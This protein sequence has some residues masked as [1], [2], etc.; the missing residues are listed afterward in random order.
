[1]ATECCKT[2]KIAIADLAKKVL[3]AFV[4]DLNQDTDMIEFVS[5]TEPLEDIPKFTVFDVNQSKRAHET[6][7]RLADAGL[8]DMITALS[9]LKNRYPNSFYVD[10][11]ARIALF[12]CPE[13]KFVPLPPAHQTLQRVMFQKSKYVRT[14]E[15]GVK[16]S[17]RRRFSSLGNPAVQNPEHKLDWWREDPGLSEHHYNWH[18]YYPASEPLKMERQGELFA[19]MHEQ[20]LARYNCERLAVGLPLVV[21]YGPG[22]GWENP[23][24][25]GYNP[26]L[27][28]YSFRALGMNIP[29]STTR[30]SRIIL[31][32]NMIFNKDRL[33]T[34]IARGHLEDRQGQHVPLS[35]TKLGCTV[36][37][38]V[39]SV[40]R[41]LYGNVH[42]NG[43]V[44]L[45]SLNDPDGRYDIEAGPMINT[46]TSAKD[47]VFYR[48]HKFVDSFF[49]YFR[50]SLDP[51]TK[52][53]L[54]I[55]GIELMD[56]AVNSSDHPD[57]NQLF[58]QMKEKYYLVYIEKENPEK[59]LQQV[60]DYTPFQY[61]FTVKNTRK[62][63]AKVVFRVFLAPYRHSDD[64]DERRNDFIELDR[65]VEEIERG[66]EKKVL[67]DSKDSSVLLP[68]GVTIEE[69]LAG[70]VG[71]A[72]ACGCGWPRNLLL[73]RGTQ[74]GMPVQLY[75]LVTDWVVDAAGPEFQDLTASVSY[76]GKQGSEYPDKRPMGFPF[77]R[78]LNNWRDMKDMVSGVKNSHVS[79]LTITFKN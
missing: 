14:L 4:K 23:L 73:P 36:E 7:R 25:E 34:G 12:E 55:E 17:Q 38:N 52:Q 13:T 75:V 59:V 64:L 72:A 49:E 71:K 41:Y 46:L 1:M 74:E 30:G 69:I 57:Q 70:D 28:G 68:P 48:W 42:N 35:M 58:T 11:L 43:H 50:K 6:A 16:V 32:G 67:R 54:Q 18:L 77:D 31:T 44:V 66:Q 10:Y 79:D 39:G 21:Q 76:C 40:N 78:P 20:K 56:V 9:D 5:I 3:R 45:A 63:A 60:L 29:D 26:N 37:A 15:T 61:T 8:E 53:D 47:P 62:D 65:F 51:Y 22:V 2:Q 19:Y 27:E 33:L 24:P